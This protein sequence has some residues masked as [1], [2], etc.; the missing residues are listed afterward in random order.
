[1]IIVSIIFLYLEVEMPA[2]HFSWDK[3][4]CNFVSDK[5]YIECEHTNTSWGGYQQSRLLK[6]EW[7]SGRTCR[8]GNTGNKMHY[9]LNKIGLLLG[10]LSGKLTSSFYFFMHRLLCHSRSLSLNQFLKSAFLK[11]N[12]ALPLSFK[13]PAFGLTKRQL[14]RVSGRRP[15]VL[16]PCLSV[17]LTDNSWKPSPPTI[18]I[19]QVKYQAQKKGGSLFGCSGVILNSK[20]R[21]QRFC[22]VCWCRQK[23]WSDS[24]GHVASEVV[25]CI[26]LWC[27]MIR[28]T[29]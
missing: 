20:A 23:A 24:S 14:D 3:M 6:V 9:K 21:K 28:L 1:M 25:N 4:D 5:D 29:S 10:P 16:S 15:I 18:P 8:E 19:M 27:F 22:C 7:E 26:L 2:N 11:I 13:A 12:D 17:T